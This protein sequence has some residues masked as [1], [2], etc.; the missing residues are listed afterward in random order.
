M[1]TCLTVSPS[2]L[3]HFVAQINLQFIA[4]SSYIW[5]RVTLYNML[6]S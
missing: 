2:M 5:L 6:Y 1:A 3:Y 4:C